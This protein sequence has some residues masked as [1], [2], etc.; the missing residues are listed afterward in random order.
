MAS[1]NPYETLTE[2][3]ILV[4]L[5][6]SRKQAEQGMYKDA[7][8]VSHDLRGKLKACNMWQEV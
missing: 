6:K 2:N 4:K 7:A 5:E 8:E 3:E 1:M